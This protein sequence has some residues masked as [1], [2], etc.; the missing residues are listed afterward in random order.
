[1]LSGLPS[2][3]FADPE[4]GPAPA[5]ELADEDDYD[6]LFDDAIDDPRVGFPD[7]AEETNRSIH[8]FNGGVDK[9]VLDPVTRAFGWL[10]P[11]PVKKGIR[12][13]FSNLGEPATTVNNL[14]QLEWQDAGVSGSRFLINTT[15]GIGG[16]F[17]IAQYVG[18]EYH[19][20][21]FGQTLALAGT[22][23]GAYLILPIFGPNN[24]RDG[25]GVLADITMHPLSWFL[26][27]AN[28]L[29]YGIYTGSQG[30]STREHHMEQLDALRESSV[31]YYAVLR[32]AY[33]QN[34]VAE[35]WKRRQ[36]RRDDWNED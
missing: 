20:S 24:V 30:L 31:D 21:D 12:R 3:V 2:G 4:P 27:P 14:L 26:G 11:N 9:W 1:M 18:L 6:P 23:S 34:R 16:F 8:T 22:P 35:V 28:F 32:S 36:D 7:P 10:F 15:L 29:I 25:F 33:Y 19:R 5:T 17:D 13:F